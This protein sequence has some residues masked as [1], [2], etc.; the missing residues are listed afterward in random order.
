MS[1][2]VFALPTRLGFSQGVTIPSGRL[3]WTSAQ[4][5]MTA[6]GRLGD[7]GEQQTRIA[8]PPPPTSSLVQVAGSRCRAC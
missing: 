3:V 6:D 4:I 7:G 8:T 2:P 5:G 1:E